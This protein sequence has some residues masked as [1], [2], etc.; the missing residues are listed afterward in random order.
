MEKDCLCIERRENCKSEQC[1]QLIF[2]STLFELLFHIRILRFILFS[3][4]FLFLVLYFCNFSFHVLDYQFHS[5]RW[6]H[7]LWINILT[8]TVKNLRKLDIRSWNNLQSFSCSFKLKIL[9]PLMVHTQNTRAHSDI[10]LHHF[11]CPDIKKNNKN[12]W[13]QNFRYEEAKRLKGL[14]KIKKNV[15]NELQNRGKIGNWL[16]NH[17]GYHQNLNKN[18]FKRT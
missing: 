13:T 1:R 8:C 3:L 16:K 11:R 4:L 12:S 9:M 2:L 10:C 15:R 6:H 7:K 14:F 17:Y 5:L 18:A